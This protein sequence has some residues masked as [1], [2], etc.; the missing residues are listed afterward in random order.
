MEAGVTVKQDLPGSY[1]GFI[2]VLEG[3]G[4]FG[5][6][7]TQG[8]K[9]QVL[10]LSRLEN[11]EASEVAITAVTKLRVLLYAGE[12]LREPIVAYGPFVMNTEEQIR[13]AYQDYQNGKFV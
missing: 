2:Y 1:N 10:H 7:N 11:N 4:L 13:E 12:P 6:E 5:S 8:A 3:Q 9:R